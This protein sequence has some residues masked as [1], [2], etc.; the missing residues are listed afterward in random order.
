MRVAILPALLIL[1]AIPALAQTTPT[2]LTIYNGDYAVARTTID[3]DLHA[4]PNDVLTTQVT[5]ALEPDSVILRDPTARFVFKVAEQNYDASVITQQ[6]LLKKFEGQTIDFGQGRMSDGSTPTVQGKIIRAGSD[7]GE[8]PLVEVHGKLVFQLPGTPHFPAGMDGMLLRPTLKWKIESARPARFA[9][10]LAYITRGF[11]WQATYNVIAPESTDTT[12][13]DRAE[14]I[15]WATMQNTSGTDFPQARIKLMAG[16]VAKIRDLQQFDRLDSYAMLS[17]ASVAV[18]GSNVTQ[19][20]FDDFHLYD[21]NRTVS[22]LDGETKQV[23]FLSAKD[24]QIKRLYQFDGSATNINFNPNYFNQDS[25]FGQ[26]ENTTV[27]IRQEF[28]NAESNHLGQPMP[29][30]RMRLY[31]RDAGGQMEFVGESMIKHTPVDDT[32]SIV[33]GNAFDLKGKRTQT[34]FYT[35]QQTGNRFTDENFAIK[36][37]NAKKQPVTVIVVEHFY[38]GQNWTIREPS[39]PYRGVDSHTIEFPVEVPAGGEATVSYQVHYT[40]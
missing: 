21:L 4:G 15:G 32:V 29:A 27:A 26:G 38:R 3:L 30:G 16:D 19:K 14:I 31:R 23:E 5:R 13:G 20:A 24:V 1:A 40:W 7:R 10:E 8:Q 37:T 36:L 28:R 25:G 17:T 39:V 12:T 2:Q 9:A 35:Q 34:R 6:S 18:S 33:T 11:T 22:L